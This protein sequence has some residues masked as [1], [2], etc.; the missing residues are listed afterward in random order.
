MNRTMR[1]Y[2]QFCE[3]A[4]IAQNWL[5]HG[6]QN[7]KIPCIFDLSMGIRDPIEKLKEAFD[8][9][10][11]TNLLLHIAFQLV[12]VLLRK[13]HS[14]VGRGKFCQSTTSSR[15]HSSTTM[16]LGR[17]YRTK[18]TFFRLVSMMKYPLLTPDDSCFLS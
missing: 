2:K 17:S 9:T 4:K 8:Y 6:C 5:W 12:E 1:I 15:S 10:S 13:W 14:A 16:G 7:W 11:M 18:G 3:L